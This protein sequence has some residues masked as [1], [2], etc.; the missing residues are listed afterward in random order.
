MRVGE[1]IQEVDSR[2]QRKANA[3]RVT[4]P[5]VEI[6]EK[7]PA[8]KPARPVV[9][10]DMESVTRQIDTFLR[11]TN[12]ALQFRVDDA[13]GRMIVSITDAET[14]EVIR[15]VPGEERMAESIE[16]SIGALLDETV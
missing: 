15:Q 16:A 10:P 1:L 5:A 7:V 11:S 13:S 2:L 12:R 9:I 4:A 8:A 3:E 6:V 14:G